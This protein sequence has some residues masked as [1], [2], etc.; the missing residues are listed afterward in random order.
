MATISI[1]HNPVFNTK[2]EIENLVDAIEKSKSISEKNKK[3]DKK[4]KNSK[5]I[6]E[7]LNLLREADNIC[8]YA[9]EQKNREEAK[10]QDIIHKMELENLNYKERAK[11]ATQLTNNRRERRIYKDELEEYQGIADFA[12][13]HK[14][15][16][17]QLEQLLG[18]LRKVEKY[19][20]NRRYTP[21]VLN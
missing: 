7:F 1:T 20:E 10:T 2:E 18:Q 17:R 12:K 8:T 16:V 19:H 4:N 11:L 3:S 6:S 5:I 21:K 15:I 9:E 13:E 14:D